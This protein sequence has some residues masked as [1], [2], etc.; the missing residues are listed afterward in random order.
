M[1]LKTQF[2]SLLEPELMERFVDTTL[3]FKIHRYPVG[4]SLPQVETFELG[5][6][7]NWYSLYEV[8]L[9]LW[10]KN[11]LSDGSRDPSFAPP[12]VFIGRP[13]ITE[14]EGGSVTTYSPIE[15]A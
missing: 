6:L 7:P 15:M 11:R 9:E 2:K 13:M 10:N 3:L 8:K 14:I 1:S 12:L 5:P 4:Q